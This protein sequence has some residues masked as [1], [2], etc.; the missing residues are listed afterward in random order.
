VFTA[1]YALSPYIKQIRFVFKGLIANSWYF[2]L[3]PHLTQQGVKKREAYG[4]LFRAVHGFVGHSPALGEVFLL[5]C[6]FSP[7]TAH[8]WCITIHLLFLKETVGSLR[9][10]VPNR[11]IFTQDEKR[12]NLL[13][14]NIYQSPFTSLR[15]E[16][17]Q[18]NEVIV[19]KQA[20]AIAVHVS[21]F[22][23]TNVANV[24]TFYGLRYELL[25][26]DSFIKYISQS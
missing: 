20:I 23:S 3:P 2:D 18:A 26:G 24:V 9:S 19:I 5:A 1:R 15:E 14:S 12:K 10:A 16:K 25:L 22:V 8:Q 13:R 17:S 6:R 21:S 7:V 4:F 11:H